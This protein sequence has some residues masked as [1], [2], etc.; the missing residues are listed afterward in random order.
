MSRNILLKGSLKQL[1]KPDILKG[2]SGDSGK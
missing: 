2:I 1:N